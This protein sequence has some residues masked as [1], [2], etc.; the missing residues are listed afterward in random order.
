MVVFAM[1]REPRSIQLMTPAIGR[2][3]TAMIWILLSE[4]PGSQ[5]RAHSAGILV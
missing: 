5:T 2:I 4:G 3:E 1:A